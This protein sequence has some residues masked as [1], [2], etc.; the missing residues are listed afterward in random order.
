MSKDK[1]IDRIRKLLALA[2]SPNEHEAASAAEKA[3]AMLAEYNLSMAEVEAVNTNGSDEIVRDDSPKPGK[4]W[5]RPLYG[6]VGRL[7]FCQYFYAHRGPL[8]THTFIGA[9]HN[10]EVAKL[11]ANYLE[12]AIIRLGNEGARSVMPHERTRYKTSFML[13]CAIRLCVRLRERLAETLRNS[14]TI[15]T[16]AGTTLPAL[17]SLYDQTNA[18]EAAAQFNEIAWNQRGIPAATMALVMANMD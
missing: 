6:A 9:R 17:A 3:Q 2:T 18:L 12:E 10:I 1:I 4:I 11:M 15:K 16:E 13:S 7:Y 14:G 8:D 5:R